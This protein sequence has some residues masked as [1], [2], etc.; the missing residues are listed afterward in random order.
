VNDLECGDLND[1]GDAE[2]LVATALLDAAG[3]IVVL[4]AGGQVRWRF[5]VE[6][7]VL[8]I[9]LGDADGDGLPEVVAGEW[10]AY[11]D[12][13]YVVDEDGRLQ[14]KHPTGGSVNRV[15]VGDLGK[16]GAPEVI[17]GADDVYVFGG[18]GELLWKFPTTSYASCLEVAGTAGDSSKHVLAATRY[19]QPSV[20]ALDSL[21]GLVWRSDLGGSPATVVSYSGADRAGGDVLV[22]SLDGTVQML[23]SDGSRRWRSQLSGPVSDVALGDVNADGMVEAV[24]GTGNCFSPGGIYVLDISTGAVLGFYEV[25]DSV[26]A[27]QV[28]DTNGW[29]GDEV[30]AALDGGEVLVLRWVSE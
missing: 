26:G 19:P 21:G 15:Q 16:D 3:E 28:A 12:T 20:F 9:A 6:A 10:G 5:G 4:D 22:G 11:G 24:V 27:L 14:W 2:I 7:S 29:G 17:A 30:V 23:D 25:W 8:D 1:D 13:I 18:T